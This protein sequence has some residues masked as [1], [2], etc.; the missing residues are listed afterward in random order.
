MDTSEHAESSFSF[1]H[2]SLIIL[3]LAGLLLS[4]VLSAG[5][6]DA[7]IKRRILNSAPP[8]YPTLAR[9]M[10]LAGVVKI[11]ALVAPD[12]SVKAVDIKGGHPVLAQA[13]ANTIRQWKWE[14][15]SRESHEL[16]E[17]RFTPSE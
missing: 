2:W 5:Q 1:Q 13:A 4:S 17:V 15:T 6:K 3:F 8:A 12:G 10:A 11:D 16:V 9:T 7:P 14:P